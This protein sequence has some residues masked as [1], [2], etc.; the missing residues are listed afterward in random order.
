MRNPKRF[1]IG[2]APLQPLGQQPACHPSWRELDAGVRK[3]RRSGGAAEE[4]GGWAR[5]RGPGPGSGPWPD[6][7]SSCPV[8][9]IARD[10]QLGDSSSVARAR[11]GRSQ[12]T[13]RRS[14]EPVPMPPHVLVADSRERDREES[15]NS[16]A[17]LGY[18]VTCVDSAE[19]ALRVRA[20][21]PPPDMVILDER[22]R[23]ANGRDVAAALKTGG[24]LPV[25]LRVSDAS[26]VMPDPAVDW[27]ISRAA[28]GP[29]LQAAVRALLQVRE[30][31]GRM[32]TRN[33][34]LARML[35]QH[36]ELLDFQVHDVRR[37]LTTLELNLAF[38]KGALG[39]PTGEIGLAL[40]DSVDATRRVSRYLGDMLVMAE[41]EEVGLKLD[42]GEVNLAELI[43][44]EAAECRRQAELRQVQLNSTVPRDLIIEGDL[45]LLGRVFANLLD[46]ALRHAGMAGDVVVTSHETDESVEI[47]VSNTGLPLPV[48]LRDGIFGKFASGPG[49]AGSRR[50]GVG[51]YFCHRVVRAH[52]GSIAVVDRPGCA[53]SI[54]VSLPRVAD[55]TSSCR[56]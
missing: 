4:G 24:Y 23:F 31:F 52:G 29:T 43:D 25:L 56:L 26:V 38:V 14:F 16:L 53:V 1:G 21:R 10:A 19:A 6:S 44:R 46:N 32:G 33:A 8:S 11:V 47:T 51:L 18:D 42:L 50:T 39:S 5:G 9:G 36:R 45:H 40:D 28:D 54:A 17:P 55:P 35:E 49:D 7:G 3:R 41:C 34:E 48:E 13:V 15:R 22:L 27:A 12:R 2:V 30:V 20:S 37:H